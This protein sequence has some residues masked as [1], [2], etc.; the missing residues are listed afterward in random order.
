M[1]SSRIGHSTK[2]VLHGCVFDNFLVIVTIT[3]RVS[4]QERHHSKIRRSVD[5]ECKLRLNARFLSESYGRHYACSRNSVDVK[6]QTQ[7]S[8]YDSYRRIRSLRSKGHAF[9]ASDIRQVDLQ[10][11]LVLIRDHII[12]ENRCERAAR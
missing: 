8:E 6:L 1:I 3:S 12:V 5:F 7:K 9:P 4:C 10:D 11:P 2:S